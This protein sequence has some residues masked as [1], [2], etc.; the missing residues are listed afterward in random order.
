MNEPVKSSSSQIPAYQRGNRTG[1]FNPN[2]RITLFMLL[3][4]GLLSIVYIRLFNIQVLNSDTYRLA[5]RKQY[6]SKITLKPL[7][8]AILDRKLNPLVMSVDCF[9]FAADPNMVD[10]R[11]SIANLFSSVFGKESAYYLDKLNSGNNSFVWLERRTDERLSAT[12]P[13]SQALFGNANLSGVIKINESKRINNYG[14]LAA[15]VIGLTDIDNI[16]IS[17][18]EMQYNDSLTGTDGFVIMQKDGL[19]RKRPAAEYPRTEPTNGNNI[20]LT[21]D[22]NIQKIV[23]E[24][25]DNAVYAND[26]DG[27]KCVVM[28]V[29]TGEILGIYSSVK[30]DNESSVTRDKLSVVTDLYEPGSTFKLV[31]AAA[32]LEEGIQDRNDII[33]IHGGELQVANLRITDAHKFNSLSFQ[34]V[35]EQSSN[36]GMIQVATKLG[37]KRFYKYARDFGFGA[38]TGI[39][40]P[41]ES[42]GILKRPVE[43]SPVSLKFMAIGYEILVTALQMT[44]AYAAIANNGIMM[45][46]YLV[47]KI[48]SPDGSVIRENNPT[49]VR[50]VVSKSNAET[51]TDLLYGVVERGTGVEAKVSGIKIAGKTGTAQ[52][53]VKGKY[54][55]DSYTS[56]F[57]GYFPADDPAI[58][59]SVIIDAPKAD[60][61]YGGRVAAPV[62]RSIAGKIINLTGKEFNHYLDNLP[63]TT[64]PVVDS[65][66][67]KVSTTDL[68]LT[69]FELGDAVRILTEKRIKYEISAPG[70]SAMIPKNEFVVIGQEVLSGGKIKLILQNKMAREVAPLSNMPDLSGLS[71]RKAIKLISNFGLEF[72]VTGSGRVL[73]QEPTPGTVLNPSSK[74]LIYCN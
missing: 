22:M 1:L 27:A 68:N 52:K 3:L 28:S 6:E 11:D 37:E 31:T 29:R 23:E 8:G 49:I 46:P 61:Y 33:Q 4:L 10:D 19:G 41:G 69:G 42:K 55:K 44:S 14:N 56:S 13:H 59:I 63:Q 7:R 62:F 35:I 38:L 16:G 64:L 45:K 43:F 74:I 71:L 32:A 48:M 65:R 40:F 5:A 51:L 21:L 25:L 20:V 18:I 36:V 72:S 30:P 12:S 39:D 53:L 2:R 9:S 66:E 34:Q 73:R 15:K 67:E 26:A 58:V 57:I 17:G 60:G 54:S 24:E 70:G 47:K 50:E